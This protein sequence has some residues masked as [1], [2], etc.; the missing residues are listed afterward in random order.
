MQLWR[1]SLSILSQDIFGQLFFGSPLQ[2]RMLP[3]RHWL[4]TFNAQVVSWTRESALS[5]L[6]PMGF[7]L[8][9]AP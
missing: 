2:H 7:L 3:G 1:L 4:D 5:V 8:Q 6:E 9:K